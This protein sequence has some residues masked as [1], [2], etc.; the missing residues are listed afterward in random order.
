MSQPFKPAS[1]LISDTPAWNA[2]V[3]HVDV[4]EKTHLRVRQRPRARGRRVG[5]CAL[6]RG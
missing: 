6:E 2:L 1:E 3:K 5:A 4:I